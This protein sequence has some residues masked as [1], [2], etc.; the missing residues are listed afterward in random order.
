MK[1]M[2]ESCLRKTIRLSNLANETFR[3]SERQSDTGITRRVEE[4]A[5]HIEYLCQQTNDVVLDVYND[6]PTPEMEKKV[7][8]MME[9]VTEHEEMLKVLKKTVE[10]LP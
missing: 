1:G 5:A 7:A 9:A 6:A 2:M 3:A 10:Q 8:V 4:L